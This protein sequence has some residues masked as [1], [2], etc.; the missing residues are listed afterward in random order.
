MAFKNKKD[1]F[2][3]LLHDMAVNLRE[4]AN[5]FASYNIETGE[6]LHTFS[7]KMKEYETHGDSLVHK[8][9]L[10]LN[11]A[12]ITP[13]ER[14]DMLE[15][16]N[17]LDDVMDGFEQ[18]AFTFEICHIKRFDDYMQKFI[19]AIEASTVEIEKAVDLVF[20]KKLKDVR[21]LA[22]KIKNYESIC[23]EVYRESLIQLFQNEENPIRLIRMKEV[24]ENFEEIADS[25]QS[26][27]NTLESIVMKNA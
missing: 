17:R 27:A 15:L 1:R 16:T 24:Y 10:E 21:T 22:I 11:D 26:V 3:S 7:E 23:D 8:M 13:I 4:G 14:E 25:C 6:D 18:I 19:D 9:I 20:D 12:F 2:A 5:Y